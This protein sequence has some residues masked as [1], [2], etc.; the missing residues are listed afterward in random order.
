MEDRD[1]AFLKE[2]NNDSL[3]LLA[4]TIVYDKDG[5]ERFT[6]QLSGTD[7]YKEN[8]PNHMVEIVPRMVDEIQR[9]GGNTFFN[10]YRGHG[11]TYREILEQ[12]ASRLKVNYNKS[13]STE[14]IE[15]YLLQ[16]ILIMSIDKMTEEDL[17][18]FSEKYSKAD[19]K[20][21]IGLLEVGSPL[22]IRLTGIIVLQ[23]SKRFAQNTVLGIL[24][25]L[26]GGR[27]FAFLTGPIG[28]VLSGMW[29]AFDVAG[30]AYRVLIPCT[31]TVAYLRQIKDK[32]DE[33]MENIF[34]R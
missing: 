30:P 26:V 22:F 34:S 3:R 8:Y 13:N 25:K 28:W 29:A 20:A 33:E 4:D 32:T 24:S 5:A 9:Y 18:H 23:L 7:I 19:L 10:M 12:V 14:L 16:H 1:L 27:A 17:K 31:I 15:Q 2:C 6:E 21:K 11:V